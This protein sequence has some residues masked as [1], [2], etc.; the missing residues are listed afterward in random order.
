MLNAFDDEPRRCFVEP[1]PEMDLVASKLSEAVDALLAGDHGLALRLLYEADPKVV[2]DF[3]STIKGPNTKHIH[4]VRVVP[5]APPSLSRSERV[6]QRMPGRGEERRV[7]ARDGWRCRFCG[8]RV[9]SK[10]I[11][12]E[13]VWRLPSA[14]QRW[15]ERLECHNGF[16]TLNASLDHI[17][18]HSRGGD[19]SNENLVTACQL[20]QFGRGGCT[21]EEVGFADPRH[22]DPIVDDWDGLTR[23]GRS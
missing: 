21:L 11:R 19:N 14:G 8:C 15:G 2:F 18:P 5:G 1:I 7:F 9:V 6:T 13:I 3:A 10:E 20:C 12:R 23:L 4:R 22:W 17:L 16:D